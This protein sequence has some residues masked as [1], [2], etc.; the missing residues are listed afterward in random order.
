MLREMT[1]L[2]NRA[3]SVDSILTKGFGVPGSLDNIDDLSRTGI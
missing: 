2:L 1:V 3:D